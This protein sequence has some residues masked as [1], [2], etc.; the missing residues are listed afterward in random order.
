MVSIAREFTLYNLNFYTSFMCSNSSFMTVPFL[1]VLSKAK[2]RSLDR[3]SR[4]PRYVWT[5]YIFLALFNKSNSWWTNFLRA[6][7]LNWM[8]LTNWRTRLCLEA[9]ALYVGRSSSLTTDFFFLIR[10]GSN[11]N[12]SI[13]MES[14]NTE[15]ILLMVPLESLNVR[16]FLKIRSC[17]LSTSQI[18]QERFGIIHIIVSSLFHLL[19]G[20][21]FFKRNDLLYRDP[22]LRWS[23][24]STYN[25]WSTWSL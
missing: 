12:Y 3:S 21:V 17:M 14:F 9:Q 4:E 1:Q 22:V 5:V 19:G 6:I 11:N 8:W 24:W 15:L 20:E 16:S 2:K 7:V 25:L 10:H 18:R 23:S 13:G